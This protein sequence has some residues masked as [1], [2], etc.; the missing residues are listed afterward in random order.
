MSKLIVTHRRWDVLG[1]ELAC[2][3]IGEKGWALWRAHR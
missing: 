2:D 3:W 1:D